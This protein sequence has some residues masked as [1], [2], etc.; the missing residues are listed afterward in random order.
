[1]ITTKQLEELGFKQYSKK[2]ILELEDWYFYKVNLY[3][4]DEDTMLMQLHSSDSLNKDNN[5]WSVF[6]AAAYV[7]LEFKDFNQL[8]TYIQLVKNNVEKND[9][10][11]Y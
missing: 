1:M 10:L 3:D 4:E 9:V 8:T 2:S 5:E 7:Y 6:V 11:N